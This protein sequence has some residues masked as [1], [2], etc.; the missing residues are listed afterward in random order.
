MAARLCKPTKSHST[1]QTHPIH[2]INPRLNQKN[3]IPGSETQRFLPTT[4]S[5]SLENPDAS[6]V[7]IAASG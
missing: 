2:N 5:N 7:I 3:I 6:G 1:D 4:Q